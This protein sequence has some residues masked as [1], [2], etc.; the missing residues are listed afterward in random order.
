VIT[1]YAYEK[2]GSVN[3]PPPTTPVDGILQIGSCVHIGDDAI[4]RETPCGAPYSGVVVAF[5]ARDGRCP[6]STEGFRDP[7]SDG[8]V[9]I[10]R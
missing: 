6:P 3:G 10:R 9:C 7:T 5:I 8:Y 2:S 1:A 4:A